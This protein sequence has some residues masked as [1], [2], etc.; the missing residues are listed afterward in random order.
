MTILK[1]EWK[2]V[3]GYEGYYEVSNTGKVRSLDRSVIIRG[4]VV[5][6]RKGK[7][8]SSHIDKKG[9]VN[10]NISK[11]GKNNTLKVHR[12]VAQSFIPNPNKY[13]QVNHK[14][15]D[16]ANNHVNNLEWCTNEYNE[17]YGTRSERQAKSLTNGK[18]SKPVKQMVNG[19]VVKIWPSMAEADRHGFLQGDVSKCCRG[20]IKT[21]KGYV[22]KYF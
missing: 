4:G 15:E 13:P 3:K 10:V 9:Y 14:D 5:Q 20:L 19:E 8:I 7:M 6:H 12:L 17:Y 11:N 16:K 22:W 18:T 2:P 21:Y 1:E